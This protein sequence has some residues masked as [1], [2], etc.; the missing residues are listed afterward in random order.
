M[1]L[2]LTLSILK[3]KNDQHIEKLNFF[4]KLFSS[5]DEIDPTTTTTTMD[6]WEK[7]LE[8]QRRERTASRNQADGN[9]DYR[10]VE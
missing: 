6:P 7:T 4:K 2:V 1:I 9:N 5:K 8:D 10:I 3:G